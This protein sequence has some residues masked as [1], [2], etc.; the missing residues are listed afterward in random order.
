V[1][2]I[3]YSIFGFSKGK[4]ESAIGI[5]IRAVANK[6]HILFAQFLKDGNSGE[7][8]Y[9][10]T[11]CKDN[12]TCLAQGTVGFS[13]L[14]QAKG[15][16]NLIARI[17]SDL[18]IA[19]EMGRPYT[20][21]VL[22]EVLVALDKELLLEEEF[23]DLIRVIQSYGGD[24]YLTG[25]INSSKLRNK[26]AEL[27]DVCGDLFSEA[28]CFNKRCSGCGVEYPYRFIYCP[29]CGSELEGGEPCIKGRDY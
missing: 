27:S 12:I 8:E 23:S 21:V 22:D 3:I 13:N 19:Y 29:S 10:T 18:F 6:E 5:T 4:T 1:I 20:L 28:H 7:I 25:R 17:R 16:D 2:N 11:H 24:V 26:I 14:E 15:I 9:F